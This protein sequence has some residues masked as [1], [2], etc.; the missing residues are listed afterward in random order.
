MCSN[1]AARL[2]RIGEAIDRLAADAAQAADGEPDQAAAR[3]AAIWDMLADLDPDLAQR[4]GGYTGD[5]T[6]Q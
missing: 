4:R 6:R 3:L 5:V 1:E 2:T